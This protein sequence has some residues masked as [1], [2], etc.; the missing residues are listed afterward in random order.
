MGNLFIFRAHFSEE[1]K[2]K[3][4]EEW[5][6]SETQI[7]LKDFFDRYEIK[8]PEEFKKYDGKALASFNEGQF[9]SSI[10]KTDGSLLFNIIQELKKEQSGVQ[11]KL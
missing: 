10:N 8:F 6:R 7:F 2:Q 1:I 9:Q 11:G 4:I 5:T 3:S